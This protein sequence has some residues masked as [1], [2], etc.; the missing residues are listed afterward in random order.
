MK[1]PSLAQIRKLDQDTISKQYKDSSELMEHAALTFV[2]WFVES[3]PNTEQQVYIF[4]GTGNNGGDGL[5]TARLL[6]EKFYPVQIYYCKIGTPSKDNTVMMEKLSK[7]S[8]IQID[9][10]IKSSDLPNLNAS[11]III[12]AIFGTGINRGVES[13]WGTVINHI[14]SAHLPTIAI[15]IPSG[16]WTNSKS[17][18]PIVCATQTFSFEF[19][20]TQFLFPAFSDQVG[21]W[22]FESIGLDKAAIGA[23]TV[24]NYYITNDVAKSILKRRKKYSHKGSYGHALLIAGTYGMYGA[25]LLAGQASLRAG[26]GLLTIHVPE[27]GYNIIQTALPEAMISVD[28]HT[29]YFS[30]PPE[31]NKYTAIGIGC[32]LGEEALTKD[33][34]KEILASETLTNLRESPTLLLDADALNIIARDNSLLKHLPKGTILTPHPGECKRLFGV[35]GTD[36]TEIE[37]LKSIAAQHK[38]YI[39]LKRAHT[40][41]ICPDQKCY[42]NSTGNPGMATAGSGDILSGIITGLL[43]QSYSPKE[44]C[45]L[46]VYLHGLAGDL[47]VE[48]LTE[49]EALIARDIIKFMGNAFKKIRSN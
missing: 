29:Y 14:N 19:P 12:D 1:I 8:G 40:V 25:A 45:I 17:D 3:Y 43:A 39:V 30:T 41:I 42:F 7:R 24:E 33:A 10:I 31:L 18:D 46:G 21:E 22:H 5:A 23:L 48:H 6:N 16:L 26:L 49:Q 13:Y 32:G 47:A 9:E 37:K 11:G 27:A 38:I 2:N 15:D 36:L 34:L 4:C 44:A 35:L 20:K 28:R